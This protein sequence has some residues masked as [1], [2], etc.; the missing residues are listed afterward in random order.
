VIS[1]DKTIRTATNAT[2]DT[3]DRLLRLEFRAM[4]SKMLA[5]LQSDAP[6]AGEALARVPEWFESWEQQLSRF[7]ADSELS[8]LNSS[9]GRAF[10]VS[11]ELWEVLMLALAAANDTGGL[12][13]PAVLNAVEAA[14]YDRTFEAMDT[15]RPEPLSPE[16][17]PRPAPDWREIAID[18]ARRTVLLPPGTRLDFGGIAKGWAADRAAAMLGAAGPALVDA[19]GDIAVSESMADGSAWPIGVADPADL[20]K[21][22]ELLR[23]GEREALPYMA[24]VATS[25]RDYHRW[26]RNGR[27]AHHIVD[28]RTGEPAATDVLSATVL[29]PSAAAAEVAAKTVL[30]LGSQAGLQWLDSRP[31]LAGLLVLEDGTTLRSQKFS[32]YTWG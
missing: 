20:D 15:S 3:G 24:A 26:L 6:F 16:G 2:P 10:Q 8:L 31:E 5:L 29:G 32:E 9:A 13:T 28:P 22:I 30:I 4:G 1:L 25:G 11:P 27:A 18:V 12:V 14:G 17:A 19:G 23:L 7:R 21:Q